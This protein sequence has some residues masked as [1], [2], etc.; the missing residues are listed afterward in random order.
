MRR[1]GRMGMRRVTRRVTP[2]AGL[3]LN[4]LP[5]KRGGRRGN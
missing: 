5:M 1:V 3:R 2:K 4:S